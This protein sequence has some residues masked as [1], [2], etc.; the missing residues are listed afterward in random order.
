MAFVRHEKQ[1]HG[2]VSG[3]DPAGGKS[4]REIAVTGR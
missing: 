4:T 3:D 1:F 2:G